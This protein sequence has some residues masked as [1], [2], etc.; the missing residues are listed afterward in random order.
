MAAAQSCSPSGRI[1]RQIAPAG[2][3]GARLSARRHQSRP[4]AIRDEEKPPRPSPAGDRRQQR[5]G[6]GEVIVRGKDH[7]PDG[8]SDSEM[9]LPRRRPL[10]PHLLRHRD[11]GSRHR[12][13]ECRHVSRHDRAEGHHAVPLGQRRR[14][15]MGAHFVNMGHARSKPMPVATCVIVLGP[16]H[17]PFS[18]GSP[19]PSQACCRIRRDGRLS[20]ASRR[21]S[22]AA[23]PSISKC[24]PAPRSSSKAPSATTRLLTICKGRTPNKPATSP[25]CRRRGRP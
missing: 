8:I 10:H 2:G 12:R 9:A 17:V 24:R 5:A 14:P 15:A 18:P 6:Q 20:A 4:G 11:Q 3:A 21:S 1:R 22:F 16:D 7:R 19:L 23:R 25:T 13:G